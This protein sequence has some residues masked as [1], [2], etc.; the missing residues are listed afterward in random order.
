MDNDQIARVMRAY[1]MSPTEA[2]LTIFLASEARV[3]SLFE[4]AVFLGKRE[5]AN[6]D[7]FKVNNSLKVVIHRIR[8]KIGKQLLTNVWGIGYELTPN[9]DLLEVLQ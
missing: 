1:K 9:A 8:S 5:Q 4:I 7:W 6:S 3:F 2:R